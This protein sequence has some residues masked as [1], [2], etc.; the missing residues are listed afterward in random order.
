MG[1]TFED[2]H[3]I[4]RLSVKKSTK[5]YG[6]SRSLWQKIKSW[7]AKDDD[8]WNQF[9]IFNFVLVFAVAWAALRVTLRLSVPLS[10]RLSVQCLPLKVGEEDM[11]RSCS[12]KDL[13]LMWGNTS[14]VTELLID[15]IRF[16][17]QKNVLNVVLLILFKNTSRL[18]WNRRVTVYYEDSGRYMAKACVDLCHQCLWGTGGFG[19]F[20]DLLE[21]G[22]PYNNQT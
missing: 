17:S 11:K 13:D 14:L 6:C 3:L 7:W 10:V 18:S 9:E 12:K 1:F 4:K 8:Q 5:H 15:G 22:K 16:S 21:N 2:K 20:G 19:E